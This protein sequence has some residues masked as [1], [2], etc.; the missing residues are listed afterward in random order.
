MGLKD[1]MTDKDHC[2]M[3]AIRRLDFRDQVASMHV[4]HCKLAVDGFN[5]KVESSSLLTDAN[6]QF[7]QRID[8]SM[9]PSS[10]KILIDVMKI[11]DEVIC[12]RC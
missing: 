1:W 3:G 5:A 8:L 12:S 4:L 2:L 6:F 11:S 10:L 9:R 7:H